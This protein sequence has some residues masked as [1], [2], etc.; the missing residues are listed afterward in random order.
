MNN[1]RVPKIVKMLL[2]FFSNHSIAKYQKI[3]VGPFGD[4]KISKVSVLKKIEWGT[5]VSSGFVCH[6]K[7][8]YNSSVPWVKWYN[9]AFWNF[10]ELVWSVRVN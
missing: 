1:L 4:R 6:A 8:Y 3:E 7:K 5:L 2:G 10:V 9:L